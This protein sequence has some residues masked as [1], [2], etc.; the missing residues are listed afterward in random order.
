MSEQFLQVPKRLQVIDLS[1][2][3]ITAIKKESF[4][5]ASEWEADINRTINLSFCRISSVEENAFSDIHNI[6]DL[7]LSGNGAVPKESLVNV[8][9]ELLSRGLDRLSLA[10]MNLTSIDSLFS[11]E[12]SLTFLNLSFNRINDLPEGT[13]S[14]VRSIQVLDL[15]RNELQ[16]I[17]EGFSTLNS[18]QALN[19]SHNRMESFQ[20]DAVA[21]W[22]D[23]HTLDL[24]HNKLSE[25]S[26]V[27]LSSLTNLRY[28]NVSNNM[29]ISAALPK[30]TPNLQF[31]DYHSNRLT[32]FHAIENAEKL[33]TVDL[34][35]NNIKSVDSF[36]FKGARFL[37]L[38]NFSRNNITT[39]DHRAF[40]PQSS[41]VID[42]SRNFL[43]ELYFFHWVA[44]QKLYLSHNELTKIDDQA[45]H[46][47]TGLEELDLSH[48]K[49]TTLHE[50]LLQYLTGLKHL[51]IS[52]NLLGTN[53]WFELFRGLELLTTLDLGYNDIPRLNVSMFLPLLKIQSLTLSHNRLQN[54][55][56]NV[57]KDL[58]D[59]KHIDLSS[60]PF[61]CGC[62]TLELKDWLQTTDVLIPGLYD[63]NSTAYSCRS[64]SRRFGMHILGWSADEFECDKTLLYA[65]AFCSTFIVLTVIA[66]IS[67]FLYR[68]CKKIQN[69][70]AQRRRKIAEEEEERKKLIKKVD[71]LRTSDHVVSAGIQDN[72]DRS[73]RRVYH[74]KGIDTGHG[75]VPW[76]GTGQRSEREKSSS[77]SDKGNEIER[78]KVGERNVGTETRKGGGSHYERL[79][80]DGVGSEENGKR[81]RGVNDEKPNGRIDSTQEGSNQKRADT[82]TE[83]GRSSSEISHMYRPNRQSESSREAPSRYQ[84]FPSEVQLVRDLDGRLYY[85][86]DPRYRYTSDRRGP[87]IISSINAIP[88]HWDSTYS[89]NIPHGWT[90]QGHRGQYYRMD[91]YSTLPLGREFRIVEKANTHDMYRYPPEVRFIDENDPKNYIRTR[92]DD[93]GDN[94]SY[95]QRSQSFTYLPQDYSSQASLE[96]VDRAQG[97]YESIEQT[98]RGPGIGRRATS[99]PFLASEGIT[100]WV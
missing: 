97:E 17:G 9:K 15:S 85:E 21:Q 33:E 77:R 42:L 41:L 14:T 65:V 49:L 81:R 10:Y 36:L 20:G 38:V 48:N 60:N 95:R 75:Y 54:I 56:P 4:E 90:S 96:R 46:G 19:V 16:R 8:V 58:N 78:V 74:K 99:Q 92:N 50:D 87:Y 62:G 25:S 71:F 91:G 12:F 44:T 13:F 93:T 43:K 24:S 30:S 63:T 61:H 22:S 2:N 1:H 53:P 34:S 82:E 6:Q 68:F 59:L 28:L 52:H 64:P 100:D 40:L 72:I 29:L 86:R 83:I 35:D 66:L 18:L 45:F 3:Q 73:E 94:V 47:M 39:F 31:L 76:S 23:L 79:N 5:A 51:N 57:F 80:R 37:K 27:D 69:R 88:G 84:E 11:G 32:E 89:W 98:R 55:N 70:R 26:R 67:C 7:D